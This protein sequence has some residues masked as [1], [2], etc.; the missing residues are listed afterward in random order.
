MEEQESSQKDIQDPPGKPKTNTRIVGTTAPLEQRLSSRRVTRLQSKGSFSLSSSSDI[1]TLTR[2]KSL[3]RATDTEKP[4]RSTRKTKQKKEK[5]NPTHMEETLQTP[6]KESS[7]LK[8]KTPGEG[9]FS[10]QQIDNSKQA[11]NMSPPN[12]LDDQTTEIQVTQTPTKAGEKPDFVKSVRANNNWKDIGP[13]SCLLR[14]N[15]SK[16]LSTFNREPKEDSIKDIENKAKIGISNLETTISKKIYGYLMDHMVKLKK[17]WVEEI[18]ERPLCVDELTKG[19]KVFL[20]S[21]LKDRTLTEKLTKAI[22]EVI[23]SLKSELE[24]FN[25]ENQN[26]MVQTVLKDLKE[27]ATDAFDTSGNSISN[28]SINTLHWD[29]KVCHSEGITKEEDFD[30][31]IRVASNPKAK[32]SLELLT[33]GILE[34]I[35]L[36]TKKSPTVLSNSLEMA[37]MRKE[38]THLKDIMERQEALLS[39]HHTKIVENAAQIIKTYTDENDCQVRMKGVEKLRGYKTE[40][41]RDEICNLIGSHFNEIGIKQKYRTHFSIDLILP[42]PKSGKKPFPPLAILKFNSKSFRD[43]FERDFKAHRHMSCLVPTRANLELPPNSIASDDDIKRDIIEQFERTLDSQEKSSWKFTAEGR[44]SAMKGIT[45]TKK[46]S[47]KPRLIYVEFPDFTSNLSWLR[48][49]HGVN[50]FHDFDFKLPV[51]NPTVRQ[52]SKNNKAYPKKREFKLQDGSCRKWETHD[53]TK[54]WG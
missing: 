12:N 33:R 19:L 53:P 25:C 41:H 29:V 38:L 7:V 10:P 27:K 48:Y 13:G 28:T 36:D 50:P 42:N 37:Q 8:R 54:F 31:R 46:H 18:E 1:D 43:S 44:K 15:V 4:S 40:D 45:I 9:E 20:R 21:A 26:N 5:I 23:D 14:H 3:S 6:S 34:F 22:G 51:P 35:L 16:Q 39:N 30:E 2:S 52:E 17:K 49:L 47:F 11:R 24:E 32:S